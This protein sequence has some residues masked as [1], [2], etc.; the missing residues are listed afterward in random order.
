MV[1]MM[2]AAILRM[3]ALLL[4]VLLMSMSSCGDVRRVMI[5][6]GRREGC[7]VV[8]VLPNPPFRVVESRSVATSRQGDPAFSNMNC[9][10]FCCDGMENGVVPLFL[11]KI[12]ISFL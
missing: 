3:C 2:G 12:L 7:L 1:F 4:P 9:A 6:E 10:I 11:S 5:L 8:S